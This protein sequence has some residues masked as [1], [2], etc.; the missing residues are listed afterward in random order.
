MTREEEKR[1]IDSVCAGDAD[2]FEALVLEHQTRIYN[3]ALRIL[4]NEADAADAT[5]EA[6]LK[7]YTSLK[8][9]RGDS[10]FSTWLCRLTNNVCIDMLRRRKRQETVPLAREDEDGEETELVL[11]D[12]APMPEEELLRREQRDAVRAA[13]AALPED[14]RRILSLR[15]LGEL[16]YEEIGTELGLEP[17]TVKSRLNRARKKLC[18]LLQENGNFSALLPSRREEGGVTRG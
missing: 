9:F 2:A 16:S 15:E 17:G 4:G 18:A 10:R 3:L 6:F 13:L 8:D 5:Q 7:A 12:P 14:Y 11:P 1:I